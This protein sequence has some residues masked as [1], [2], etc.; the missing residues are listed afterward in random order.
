MRKTVFITL[1][2]V[3]AMILLISGCG[4]NEE[5]DVE[6]V[7]EEREEIVL[8]IPEEDPV[9]E[10][11]PFE[12][13]FDDY[14]TTSLSDDTCEITA[15]FLTTAVLEVPETIDGKTVVGICD[16][17]LSVEGVE[18]IILPDTVTYIN[19]NA[20]N[21]SLELKKVVF[22]SGL[23]TVGKMAFLN[24]PNLESLEFPEGVEEIGYNLIALNDVITEV[25]IP[26]SVEKFTGA[27]ASAETCPNL[28]IVTPAGSAA[29]QMAI[30]ADLPVRNT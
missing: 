26:A 13:Q 4:Q 3:M 15:C 25:Y 9:T 7:G 30:E 1:T 2:A 28:V 17:G 27:I 24:C 22:G 11:D 29:E 10:E 21:G 8:E 12:I 5:M 23:K 16:F 20:F 18:E 6:V 19:P 14:L